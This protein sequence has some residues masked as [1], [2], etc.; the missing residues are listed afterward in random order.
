MESITET[1]PV[2]LKLLH[3]EQLLNQFTKKRYHLRQGAISGLVSLIL[4]REIG[5]EAVIVENL[6]PDQMYGWFKRH[7]KVVLQL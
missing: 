6:T 1:E 2:E 3:F 4:I 7:L 5:K